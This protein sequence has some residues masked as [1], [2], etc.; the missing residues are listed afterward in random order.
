MFALAWLGLLA[1]LS[2][3]MMSTWRYPSF[4]DLHLTRPLSPVTFVLMGI[5][6]YLIWNYSQQALLAMAGVY[7]MSGIAIRAGGIAR[8]AFRRA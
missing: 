8:R 5:L 3:L 2:F 4:K 1:L 6:I 7:V